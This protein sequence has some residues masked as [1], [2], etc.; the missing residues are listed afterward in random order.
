MA[1]AQALQNGGNGFNTLHEAV[2]FREG[3]DEMYV[4][5][6]NMNDEQANRLMTVRDENG[7]DVSEGRQGE[8]SILHLLVDGVFRYGDEGY[9]ELAKI[10]FNRFDINTEL[11]NSEHEVCAWVHANACIDSLEMEFPDLSDDDLQNRELQLNRL[12]RLIEQHEVPA[13]INN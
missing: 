12:I 7:N 11:E 6:N 9:I 5:V 1:A 2:V 4:M 13:L 10:L 8:T 3:F